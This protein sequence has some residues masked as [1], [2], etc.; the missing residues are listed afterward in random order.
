MEGRSSRFDVAVVEGGPAFFS[1]D[2]QRAGLTLAEGLPFL[3]DAKVNVD[4]DAAI[5]RTFSGTVVDDTGLLTPR[6][7]GDALSPYG[8]EL[9]ARVGFRFVDGSIETLP[10]GVFRITSAEPVGHG[11]IKIAAKDRAIVVQESRFEAPYVVPAGKRVVEPGVG[12]PGGA[13]VELIASRYPGLTYEADTSVTTTLPLTVFEEGDRSGDPWKCARQLAASAGMEVFFSPRGNVIIRKVPD[14]G[15]TPA[16][17]TYGGQG[18]AEIKLGATNRLTAEEAR[19]IAIVTGENSGAAPV[20]AVVEVTDPTSPLYPASFGR[21]PV[22]LASPMITTIDQ[23]VA[24]AQ[25]LLIRRAGGSEQASITAAPHPA[26]EAGDVVRLIDEKLAGGSAYAV[27]SSFSLP[28]TLRDA[29][30]YETLARRS[31]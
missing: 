22:F 23:A 2:V 20:R 1:I 10:V 3:D 27:L 25:A 14:P 4:G 17:W 6:T 15:S 8:S 12:G 21:R 26:H 24:A 19:N 18:E 29:V 13:V 5:R 11:K 31:I 30:T 28:L 9:V 16:V 7:S